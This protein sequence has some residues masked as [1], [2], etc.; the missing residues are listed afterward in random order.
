MSYRFNLYALIVISHI[1]CH[2]FTLYL[3]C[4]IERDER[5]SSIN[6]EEIIDAI[7]HSFLIISFDCIIKDNKL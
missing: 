2:I 6:N 4:V 5:F 7:F 1:C 3:V